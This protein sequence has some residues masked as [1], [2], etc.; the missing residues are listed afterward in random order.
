MN[1]RNTAQSDVTGTVLKSVPSPERHNRGAGEVD[2]EPTLKSVRAG[3]LIPGHDYA[4]VVRLEPRK[5]PADDDRTGLSNGRPAEIIDIDIAEEKR[6]VTAISKSVG[7]AAVEVLAG[8]RPVSQLSRWLD[9]QSYE[10]LQL[11]S[12]M[13]R[14]QR[15]ARHARSSTGIRRLHR[16]PQVRSA[17]LCRLNSDIYEAS[18]VVVEQ[19]RARAVALRLE[20]RK[21]LWKVTALEIG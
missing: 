5:A 7:Q 18:L 16:N 15:E 21:E 13:V 14:Q 17:K 11:R 6:R 3:E 12:T 19:T 1:A 4:P 2:S 8:T 9:P 10:R 20:Y